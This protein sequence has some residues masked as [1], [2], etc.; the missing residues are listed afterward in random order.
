MFEMPM[1]DPVEKEIDISVARQTFP[2]D[3]G[4][5]SYFKPRARNPV[6]HKIICAGE[7]AG[8]LCESSKKKRFLAGKSAEVE[9]RRLA[10]ET[11]LRTRGVIWSQR[12]FEI[13]AKRILEAFVDPS[14]LGTL[15]PMPRIE[16]NIPTKDLTLLIETLAS[17]DVARGA[18]AVEGGMLVHSKG[19]LPL[20]GEEFSR[21]VQDHLQGMVALSSGIG[22]ERPLASSLALA[23]GALLIAPAGDATIAVWTDDHADHKALLANA[24]ALL[25]TESVG[26]AGDDGGEPLPEGVVV[27][28][29]KSGID[30]VVA[31]LKVAQ[32]EY[33]TGYLESVSKEG[34]AISLTIIDGVPAGIRGVGIET[35]EDAMRRAT[36]SSNR[37]RL[38]R[39]ERTM[40]LLLRTSSVED[41]S[42]QEMCRAISECRTRSEDRRSLLAG[43][44]ET[45]YG[46][47]L[48]HEMMVSGRVGWKLVDEGVPSSKLPGTTRRSLIGP[49][50]AELQLRIQ[51]L[52][53]DLKRSEREQSAMQSRL[54]DTRK[55]RDELKTE[56]AVSR[57]LLEEGRD[58]R[59][60]LSSQ[61][62]EAAEKVRQEQRSGEEQSSRAERLARRVSE[63]EMQVKK[64]AEEMASALGEMESRQQLLNALEGLLAEEA[65]VKSELE[66]AESR[67]KEVRRL[68]DDD[69]RI[70][71]VLHEQ[72]GAQRERY[73][74]AQAELNEIERQVEQ[75][76]EELVGIES[77][78]HSSRGMVEDER[79]RV[80]EMDRKH[81][82]LQSELR[83]LMEER[84]QLMRELGDIDSRRGAGEA[85]L[86]MLIEQAE[87]LE[88]AHS[89]AIADIAE[90]ERIRARLSEE[91]LAR[92]LLGDEGGLA[93]LEPVLERMTS[94]RSR[95]F[96]VTL[97]D[98]AVE[99]GLQV[100]QHTVDEVAQ[101][102][103]H[104]LS[105]EVMELL[106][107]QAPETADTVRG[108]T[109]WSVQ[110]RLE[111]RLSETV[112]NVV[113]DLEN[114]LNEYEHSV[115]MLMH[116]REVLRSMSEMG[117]PAEAIEPLE[118]VSHMPE[119]LP[120]VSS[121]VRRL[122]QQALDDIYIES[123]LRT[124]G[125]AIGLEST[126]L[127]LEQL[128]Y[129]LDVTGLT[130]EEPAGD[131]WVFQRTGMLP[132]EA[133]GLTEIERPPI[134]DSALQ[135][136]NPAASTKTASVSSEAAVQEVAPSDS[137]QTWQ[138]ID[139]PD[140]SDGVDLT[141]R[142]SIGMP[143]R[144]VIGTTEEVDEMA[145]LDRS[146]AAIDAAAQARADT[147][148]GVKAPAD[149]EQRSALATLEDELANLDL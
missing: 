19:L 44:L 26:L 132:F 30:Q 47:E 7:A 88:S 73:R 53:S 14:A 60:A 95:G 138:P 135:H 11:D 114:L 85:E 119:S 35:V 61:L 51:S 20:D 109:K 146:L 75:R 133:F 6:G 69:E 42:L 15:L 108:L 93:M 49:V 62:D 79:L 129:R 106:G 13:V 3:F 78:L 40:R 112:S 18:C 111:H 77:D 99:R 9:L 8:W 87:E 2:F 148:M 90:A 46:F 29:S 34:P 128:K 96:S 100:I 48:G 23:D 125:E 37:L 89:L 45:L 81:T 21:V 145:K 126:V 141:S 65:R 84:R 36:T 127:V 70:Q 120:M 124:A 28:D 116:L 103:R 149:P 94:A 55:S 142:I 67:L 66:T 10:G 110:N 102:P 27:K 144:E 56:L 17:S 57:E 41:W 22:Q 104:L 101:T 76:R 38:H 80:A 134:S 31:A 147:I 117:L 52:E 16:G 32:E 71:R 121:E 39:L 123:D 122:I 92:A 64:R 12:Q 63:L 130:G 83:E 107:Q 5:V 143:D 72:V 4:A 68:S 86:R 33:L 58:E 91:P 139:A 50:V 113:L 118:K 136:M 105:T 82:L 140:E 54:D 24:A 25:A 74:L 43:R 131:L 59:V 97:L 98:R 137:S 1:G 115:T